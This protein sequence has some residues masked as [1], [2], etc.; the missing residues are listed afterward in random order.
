M[1]EPNIR[2]SALGGARPSTV[3]L[4]AAWLVAAWI[5][6][7]APA[8]ARAQDQAT[9][10]G[11]AQEAETPDPVQDP[12]AVTTFRQS[13]ASCHTIGG[14][15]LVGPDLKDVSERKDRD[16]LAGFILDPAGVLASGDP[17]AAKLKEEAGGAVMTPTPGMTREMAGRLLDLIEAESALETSQF[18][19]LSVAD[20]P[21]GPEDVERGRALFTG[22]ERL[23]NGGPSCLACHATP[24]VGGLGGGALGPDLTRVYE[25]M[26]GRQALAAWL[27]APATAT[28][29]PLFAERPLSNDEVL[30]LTAYLEHETQAARA[31][32]PG[33]RRLTFLLLGLGGAA[34]ALVLADG[35]WRR[36]LRGVRR[37]LLRGES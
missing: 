34:A 28:M 21:L 1:R 9:G 23:A 3:F 8:D 7:L 32:D 31:P 17:Y 35:V 36:R 26:G 27:Q 12:E 10:Q 20:E 22:L 19:G 6:T 25:R 2:R 4:L 18:A 33:T 5:L 37:L 14:G 15:R 13:C 29:R 30:A 24:G 11:D 16:W